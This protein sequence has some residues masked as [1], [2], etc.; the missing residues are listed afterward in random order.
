MKQI[1]DIDAEFDG[2]EFDEAAIAR[3][4]AVQKREANGWYE[5]NKQAAKKANAK[6]EVHKNRT[7]ANR[8]NAKN[9]DWIKANA[10]GVKKRMSNEQ[11][12]INHAEAMKKVHAN[13]N[14]AENRRK[15]I[16]KKTLEDPDWLLRRN[17][18]SAKAKFKP[19]VTPEGIFESLN[20]ASIH[21]A[22]IW[23]ISFE[24]A[25]VRLMRKKNKPEQPYYN[26]TQKEYTL[27]TGKEI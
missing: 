20:S 14:L 22:S 21:Y 1:I 2:V 25:R 18:N 24:L 13:S 11:G 19:L 7:N 23:Q 12:R 5:K 17:E 4:T 8:K 27:L 15:G 10:R 16:E 3:A 9:P 26:I 6:D